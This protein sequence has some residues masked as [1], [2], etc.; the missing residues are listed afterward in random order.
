MVEMV[1]KESKILIV[2]SMKVDKS[3]YKK[4][5]DPNFYW[6]K[7]GLASY[8][9]CPKPLAE[10]IKT[11]NFMVS[12]TNRSLSVKMLTLKLLNLRKALGK[13]GEVRAKIKGGF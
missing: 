10:M 13:K 12:S 5:W 11:T 8:A 2:D 1:K 9:F 4:D 6:I 7:A 3:W